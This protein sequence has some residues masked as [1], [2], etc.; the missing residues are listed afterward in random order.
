[1]QKICVATEDLKGECVEGAQVNGRDYRTEAREV[2]D[3]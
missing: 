3:E 2:G 1:M